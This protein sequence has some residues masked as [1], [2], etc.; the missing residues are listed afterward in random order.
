MAPRVAAISLVAQALLWQWE[1]SATNLSMPLR[2]AILV[3]I[4]ALGVALLGSLSVIA[5]RVRTRWAIAGLLAWTVGWVAST[6][7]V[8][9][10]ILWSL[11]GPFPMRPH[12]IP[13]LDADLVQILAT[14]GGLMIGA[15]LVTAIR[16]TRFRHSAYA[17]LAGHAA[18]G[19]IAAV[20]DHQIALATDF[21]SIAALRRNR[22][23]TDVIA[24]VALAG[25]L[26]LYWR[27]VASSH[28]PRAT[29]Q[30]HR[31]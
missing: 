11:G 23:M 16:E 3:S 9:S 15:A 7:D 24:A 5:L 21:P 27:R 12:Q 20:A 2:A 13:Q 26:W 22:D 25:V 1:T 29:T 14:V 6:A 18:F 28:L 19:V 4:A 8:S 31:T 10:L 30:G 17:L